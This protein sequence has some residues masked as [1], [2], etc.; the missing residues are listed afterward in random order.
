MTRRRKPTDP[1]D[2][3][4]HRAERIANEREIDR[5]EGQGVTVKLDPSRRII[6]AFRS[7]VFNL[8][9]ERKVIDLGHHIAAARLAQDWAEWK[10]LDG[11]PEQGERVDQTAATSKALVTDRMLKAGNRIDHAMERVGIANARLLEALIEEMVEADRPRVWRMTVERVT[12]ETRQKEQ[13]EKVVAALE[14]LRLY[15]ER[16]VRQSTT[17]SVEE[18]RTY[19]PLTSVHG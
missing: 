19:H 13:R 16:P 9:L 14:N 5:L 18:L 15:Y 3:L 10:R 7:N 1:Q 8:L 4:R 2:I 6:S 11:M 17:P 12:G